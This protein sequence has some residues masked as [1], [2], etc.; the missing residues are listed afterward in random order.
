MEEKQNKYLGELLIQLGKGDIS[1]LDQIYLIMCKILYTVGNIYYNQIA[2]IEDAIQDL[3]VILYYKAPKFKKNKNACAW[4]ITVYQN[5]IK[6]SLR[7]KGREEQ[8][9]VFY[10]LETH[11][12]I[13]SEKYIENHAFISEMFSKM[14]EYEQQL[15]IYRY[16]GSCSISEIAK[17][18]KKPKSTIESQLNKIKDKFN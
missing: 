10:D 17:I 14:T 7:G 18:M 2:D 11:D 13:I 5:S 9:D 15:F 6:N 4:I 3:L 8:I 1:K 12:K 16:W